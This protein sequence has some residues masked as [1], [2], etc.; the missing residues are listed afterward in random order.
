M[1]SFE[2]VPCM[3]TGGGKVIKGW[4]EG[5]SECPPA[6]K[7]YS[8]SIPSSISHFAI[9]GKTDLATTSYIMPAMRKLIK[10]TEGP[11]IFCTRSQIGKTKVALLGRA[12]APVCFSICVYKMNKRTNDQPDRGNFAIRINEELLRNT[13]NKCYMLYVQNFSFCGHTIEENE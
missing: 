12:I 8:L 7:P 13:E 10:Q 6:L 2:L 4:D 9:K 5:T 11:G 1:Y 3:E